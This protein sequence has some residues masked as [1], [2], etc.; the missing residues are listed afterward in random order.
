MLLLLLLLLLQQHHGHVLLLHLKL[1]V[2]LLLH[3]MMSLYHGGIMLL[4][5]IMHLLH[6][7]LLRHIYRRSRGVIPSLIHRCRRRWVLLQWW[8]SLLIC[9]RC[10]HGHTTPRQDQMIGS[11]GRQGNTARHG[12]T[13]MTE[14]STD[15]LG[16]RRRRTSTCSSQYGAGG[17]VNGRSSGAAVGHGKQSQEASCV[18]S[19]DVFGR[20][21]AEKILQERQ[22][23]PNK[24]AEAGGVSM[25]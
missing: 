7:M 20:D 23:M 3:V 1:Q 2:L 5:M 22:M 17:P 21:S 9:R 13:G 11:H 25:S 10:L 14:K 4:L 16:G 15:M 19:W 6:V 18:G 24:A 12:T 8:S